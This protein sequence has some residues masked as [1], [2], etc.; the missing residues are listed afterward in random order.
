MV[1]TPSMPSSTKGAHR[2]ACAGAWLLRMHLAAD[3]LKGGRAADHRLP[4]KSLTAAGADAGLIRVVFDDPL[5]EALDQR[6][7]PSFPILEQRRLALQAGNL[8]GLHWSFLVGLGHADGGSP[9][10]LLDARFILLTR[11]ISDGALVGQL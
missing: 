6:A 2:V 7:F 9:C 5:D 1:V 10:T 8:H 4:G 3:H 11:L